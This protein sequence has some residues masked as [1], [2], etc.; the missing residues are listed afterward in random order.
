[1]LAALSLVGCAHEHVD[2]TLAHPELAVVRVDNPQSGSDSG[3]LIS[4]NG[5]LVTTSRLIA[6]GAAV[7]VGLSDGRSLSAAFV[8]EDREGGVA[9]LKIAGDK[10]P[11][12]HLRSD[13][14]EPVMHIRVVGRAGI[15]YGIFDHWENSGQTLSITTR[16]A[17]D[18]TGAPVLADDGA[19]IGVVREQ[20]P[21]VGSA[22][23]ATPIWHV[24]RMLPAEVK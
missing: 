14:I 15:S 21:A 4:A 23:L 17:P 22:G 1:M 6:N 12:L 18:D 11:F 5:F 13:D 3:F 20:S 7:S 8:E 24:T 2:P 19:V 16:A 10:Y 9:I